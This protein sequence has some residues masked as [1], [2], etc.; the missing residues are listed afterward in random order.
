MSR[1][2]KLLCDV[3]VC[4]SEPELREMLL[5]LLSDA[6]YTA[7]VPK[8]STLPPAKLCIISLNEEMPPLLA[9]TPLLGILSG[10]LD[11]YASRCRAVLRRPF[12]FEEF[13]RI[14]RELCDNS[15][16]E[17]RPLRTG[18]KTGERITLDEFELAAVS[19][20]RRAALT[21]NEFKILSLLLERQGEVVPR[22]ELDALLGETGSDKTTVYICTLRRKLALHL[23]LEPIKSARG[24]GYMIE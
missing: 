12:S 11:A 15:A 22:G 16:I 21:P 7:A 1:R 23:G 2:E 9:G 8:G 14:V 19:G 6:G 10:E 5:I 3:L 17:S 20:R 13:R 4:P 18:S 24:K